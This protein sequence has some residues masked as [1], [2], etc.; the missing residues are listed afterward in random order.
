MFKSNIA[1][2][3]AFLFVGVF[4]GSIA[5]YLVAKP[6]QDDL[7]EFAA[8]LRTEML[9]ISKQIAASNSKR[10]RDFA[11]VITPA[12]VPKRTHEGENSYDE[13]SATIHEA[14]KISLQ[15]EFQEH[16][17]RNHSYDEFSATIHEAVRISLQEEFQEYLE[18][19]LSELYQSREVAQTETTLPQDS[20]I[21]SFELEDAKAV[22][23]SA[24]E[25]GIWDIDDKQAFEEAMSRLSGDELVEA[26]RELSI[27]IN[28]DDIQLSDD[29]SLY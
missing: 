21:I 24:I 20:E 13:F 7:Q 6:A 9:N 2:L 5:G 25:K 11:G 29:I 16:L 23:T 14:V 22:I 27:A 1:F 28:N 12:P 17:K 8:L 26:Q 18:P 3:L 10:D 19:V 15:E 4:S